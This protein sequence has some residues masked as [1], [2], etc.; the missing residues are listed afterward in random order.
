MCCTSMSDHKISTR[1]GITYISHCSSPNVAPLGWHRPKYNKWLYCH[2]GSG[3]V[4]LL[5]A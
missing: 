5:E 4:I 3:L 1:C 2:P